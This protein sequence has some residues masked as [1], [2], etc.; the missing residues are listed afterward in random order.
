LKNKRLLAFVHA[1]RGLWIALKNEPHMRFHSVSAFAVI[2]LG[3]IYP[4][5]RIEWMIAGILIALVIGLE[6]VNSALEKLCDAVHPE[7]HPMIRD[8]K[9]MAAGAV[10]WVSLI[11]AGIGAWIFI[12]KIIGQ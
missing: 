5:T 6:I 9:D 4:L 2:I 7:K 10:L 12:P 8:V 3:V 11:A 1:F